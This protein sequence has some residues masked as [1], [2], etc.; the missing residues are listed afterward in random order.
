MLILEHLTLCLCG[1]I[2]QVGIAGASSK[3]TSLSSGDLMCTVILGVD[4]ALLSFLLSFS[5]NASFFC[6]SAMALRLS[7]ID[8]DFHT[9]G[10]MFC[11]LLEFL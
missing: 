4:F 6:S 7:F 10:G 2:L 1:F 5:F 3:C 9:K 8:I 11:G